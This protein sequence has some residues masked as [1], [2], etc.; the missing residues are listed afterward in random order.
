[1]FVSHPS[2]PLYNMF[3]V[4]LA[5]AQALSSWSEVTSLTFTEIKGEADINIS[6]DRFFDQSSIIDLETF[7]ANP[8]MIWT[9]GPDVHFNGILIQLSMVTHS[10]LSTGISLE[11]FI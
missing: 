4:D 8:I 1:M 5:V 11:T 10:R 6:F 9:L 3:Q 2:P 7:Q